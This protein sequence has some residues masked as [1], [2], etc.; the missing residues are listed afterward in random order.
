MA[1]QVFSDVELDRLRRFHRD[2]PEESVRLLR[3]TPADHSFIR[4]HCGPVNRVGVAVQPR[5]R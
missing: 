1:T 2:R 4:T 3:L 5:T